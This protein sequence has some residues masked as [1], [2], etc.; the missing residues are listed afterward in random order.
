MPED[1]TQKLIMVVGKRDLFGKNN[2]DFFQGFRAAQ[3]LDYEARVLSNFG[4]MTRG[5][6]TRE[7]RSFAEQD[8][9][10]KQPVAYTLIVNPDLKKAFA[11]RRSS[12]DHQYMETRLQGKWAWGVG[13]HMEMEDM[14]DLM[15][16]NP[17]RASRT[18]ELQEEVEFADGKINDIQLLGYIYKDEGVHAVHFGMLYAAMTDAAI[19][20]P[21]DSEIESGQLMSLSELEEIMASKDCEVEG[22]SQIAAQPLRKILV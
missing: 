4:F 9:N 1:K 19:I 8:T 7:H 22:W 11:Y 3:E 10:Y 14:A 6:P 16:A 17:I 15:D 20:K 12:K 2:E 18:R 21:R 5:H 13:G